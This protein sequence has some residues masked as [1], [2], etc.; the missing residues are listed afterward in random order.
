VYKIAH[1]SDTH[2]RNLKFHKEYR[3]VFTQIYNSLREQEVSYIV[4]CGDLAHTKTQ[5]SPEY[6]DLAAD[7]LKN[8]SD[9]APTYIILG[10][11]DGNLKNDNRQDAVTPIVQALNHPNLH[12]IKDSGEVHVT[13]DLC[14]NVLSIFDEENWQEISDKNKTNIALYHGAIYGVVTDTG[15]MLEHGDHDVSIFEGFDYAMLGDIHRTN[16]ALDSDGRVRYC[17]STIQQNFGETNDKGY[18]LWNIES[19]D[20]FSVKHF[21]FFNPR[22]FVTVEINADGTLPDIT[23]PKNAQLRLICNNHIPA[24]DLKKAVD[25]ARSLWLPDSVTAQNKPGKALS[26]QDVSGEQTSENLRDLAVQEKLIKEYLDEYQLDDKTFEKIFE[27]NR[28]F[29]TLAEQ[30]EEVARNVKWSIKN[31]EWNNLFNYGE[32][33]SIDFANTN[34]IVG[35]FGKNYSGKSSVIDA[36]LWSMFNSIS[37]NVRKNVDIINQ[38]KDDASTKVEIQIDEKLYSISREAEKYTRKLYGEETTEAKTSVDFSVLDL[39]TDTTESLNGIDRK[40]TDANIRRVFGLV[41]DFLLTS[42]TSQHGSMQFINEG[43]TKRKEILS[44]FLDLELFEK[45]HKLAKNESA[46]LKK[47]IKNLES[48]D[49]GEEILQAEKEKILTEK[50]LESKKEERKDIQKKIEVL[51]EELSELKVQAAVGPKTKWI[52]IREVEEQILSKKEML[53]KIGTKQDEINKEIEKSEKVISQLLRTLEE[54]DYESLQNDKHKLEE[55]NKDSIRIDAQ[56]KAYRKE[57]EDKKNKLK[58][59]DTVPCGDSYPKCRFLVDANEQKEK[60]PEIEEKLSLEEETKQ[61]TEETIEELG[62]SIFVLNEWEKLNENKRTLQEEVSEQKLKLQKILNLLPSAKSELQSL[63]EKKQEYYENEEWMKKLQNIEEEKEKINSKIRSSNKILSD[64]DEEIGDL[65]TKKGVLVQKME[66]LEEQQSELQQMREEYNAYDLFLKA[67]H[68]NGI[69]YSIIKKRLPILNS[70]MAKILSNIVNF[71]VFFE[72]DGKKLDIYIK[73][74]KYDPRPLELGSGAEKSIA[75]IAIRLA[76][77]KTSSLPVGDLFIM[78]EPATA[79]DEENMEGFTRILDM[80]KNNFKTVILI[81]HLDA[82]KDVVDKQISIE[83]I[84]GFANVRF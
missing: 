83:K 74:P 25:V 15:Y 66:T 63:E 62:E 57:V 55:L 14:F 58:I 40:E 10:N 71:D 61:K 17:G 12:L 16:Q 8:L 48:R 19:K 23:V 1:I 11:H 80:V 24:K 31:L 69:V 13:D 51:Q 77:I 18:L 73:H 36:L 47:S 64:Y 81:S 22:P 9:I 7:F 21:P 30:D 43:S 59:L 37:K 56:I 3:E 50:E 32:D 65:S 46:A 60:L 72:D 54:Y 70:E 79:L 84:D 53:E 68:S 42:M 44:K 26:I 45:K 49:F 29:T 52:D 67:M 6:F 34:G 28:Q 38:N 33:N 82:L 5:L 20:K 4:H 39:T 35:I 75:S 78:D 2:I 27:L 76:L 41:E